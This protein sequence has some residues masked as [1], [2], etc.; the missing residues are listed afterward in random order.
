MPKLISY[1]ISSSL[2]LS[3]IIPSL[4]TNCIPKKVNTFYNFN[5]QNLLLKTNNNH[6]FIILHTNP[7][8]QFL[9]Y[10]LP[11]LPNCFPA[12]SQNICCFLYRDILKIQK[13]HQPRILLRQTSN[14]IL[15]LI[16]T[17]I[18][19]NCFLCHIYSANG[20]FRVI[21]FFLQFIQTAYFIFP[22]TLPLIP[23]SSLRPIPLQID[24]PVYFHQHPVTYADNISFSFL[25]FLPPHTAA[26]AFSA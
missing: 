5:T 8:P 7:L 25:W 6:K 9:H 14:G 3:N 22:V 19:Q 16:P 18:L 4:T 1:L 2:I 17:F 21:S 12:T 23:F 15:Q 20:L 13:L 10:P 24:F 11:T 26:T